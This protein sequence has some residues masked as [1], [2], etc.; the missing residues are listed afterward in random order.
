MANR[1]LVLDDEHAH[2]GRRYYR[3]RA[4]VGL[5]PTDGYRGLR[6]T[7]AVRGRNGHDR[8]NRI[9]RAISRLEPEAFA[10]LNDRLRS[11]AVDRGTVLA[12]A[13]EA[14]SRVYFIDTGTASVISETASGDSLEVGCVGAEGVSHVGWLLGGTPQPY[15]F[16]AQLPLTA[17]EVDARDLKRL[18][19]RDGVHPLHCLIQM[20]GQFVIA[21]LA[22]STIC[23]RFHTA[24]ERLARWLLLTGSD[25]SADV[26][27]LTHEAV[28]QMVGAPRS[29]VT[30]A[31]GK[32][33]RA[34][35]ITSA[36]GVIE[37]LDAQKLRRH[38]CEC[39]EVE[40]ARRHAFE[41]RLMLKPNGTKPKP[42]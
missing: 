14:P 13:D 24:A 39:Y 40:R 26:L 1:R 25:T 12:A 6:D 20:Y 16:V 18:L 31:V 35:C 34:G 36:R 2:G 23:A 21:Q 28:S 29:Q 11:V 41:R 9:L 42:V 19:M 30:D 38:A 22:Q 33:R 17:R 37:I 7:P 15:S 8:G 5:K 32:L 4:R 10:A 27:P 3:R